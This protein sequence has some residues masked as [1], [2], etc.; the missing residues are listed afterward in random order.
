[1]IPFGWMKTVRSLA[2][3]IVVAGLGWFVYDFYQRLNRRQAEEAAAIR[4]QMQTLR[5]QAD[6]MNRQLREAQEEAAALRQERE[7]AQRKEPSAAPVP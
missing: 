6:E 1:M 3:L 2:A 7:A 5:Q 4:Q